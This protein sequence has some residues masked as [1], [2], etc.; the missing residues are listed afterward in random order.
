MQCSAHL[1]VS[2]FQEEPSSRASSAQFCRALSARCSQSCP[3]CYRVFSWWITPAINVLRPPLRRSTVTKNWAALPSQKSKHIRLFWFHWSRGS[4]SWWLLTY[5][6]SHYLWFCWLQSLFLYK[7]DP[8]KKKEQAE[9]SDCY[10]SLLGKWSPD[11][12]GIS[13]GLG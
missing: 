1:S 9:H 7:E 6:E 10:I 5:P 4:F 12:A 13:V 8:H 3:E 11:R 2:S